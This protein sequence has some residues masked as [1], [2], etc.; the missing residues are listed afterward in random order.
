MESDSNMFDLDEAVPGAIVEEFWFRDLPVW[1]SIFNAGN[2][3]FLGSCLSASL[4]HAL[5]LDVLS[6]FYNMWSPMTDILHMF[7]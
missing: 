6:L 5:L 4:N 7:S 3:Q 2:F 1:Y